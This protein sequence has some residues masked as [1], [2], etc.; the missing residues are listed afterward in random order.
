MQ[1]GSRERHVRTGR[2]T[3]FWLG[4]RSRARRSRAGRGSLRGSAE[5]AAEPAAADLATTAPA[6]HTGTGKLTC[7][8]AERPLIAG[9][10]LSPDSGHV[11]VKL[12]EDRDATFGDSVEGGLP[13]M[14]G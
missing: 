13:D 8:R 10:K 4:C 1:R 6:T 11:L 3:G 7:W 5:S 12:G 14:S 2:F 9:G